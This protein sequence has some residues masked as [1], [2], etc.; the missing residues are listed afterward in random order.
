[1]SGTTLKCVCG[2]FAGMSNQRAAGRPIPARL[3]AGVWVVV[4]AGL[5]LAAVGAWHV[6]LTGVSAA[7]IQLGFEL[8]IDVGLP[9]L[10]IIIVLYA[11]RESRLPDAPIARWTLVGIVGLL[12][13]AGWASV[14]EL[15]AGE[16][17]PAMGTLLLGANLGIIFGVVAGLNRA[18]A[19]EKAELVERERTHREGLAMLNHLLRHHVLN[20]MTI[21]N[22]YTDEL[23]EAGVADEQAAVIE[24]QSE[25]IVTLVENVQ[26]LVESLSESADPKP[27]D[28]AAVVSRAVDDARETHTAAAFD[29][30]TEPVTVRA[31]EFL[32]A[33]VDNLLA[34]AVDHHDGDPEVH[35]TVSGGDPVVVRVADD[36]PGIPEDVRRSFAAKDDMSTAIAGEGLGLYLVHTLVTNYGG[37]VAITDNEPRGTV[38]TV[39]LPRA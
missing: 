25:R 26:T 12:L 15:L 24:R 17:R 4:V 10:A 37:R 21:I 39:E 35:V 20:G 8:F 2:Q 29:V 13:L 14:T 3:G 7:E 9:V 28:A 36:G 33:V 1:V 30:T 22:G 23:R 5:M 18:Y 38:V 27:V 6:T 32:R 34:N 19:I 11:T 16:F 31:D